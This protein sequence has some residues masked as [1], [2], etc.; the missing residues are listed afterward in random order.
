MDLGLQGVPCVVTGAS[1]GIG[2]AVAARLVDEGARVLIVARTSDALERAA[3]EIGAESLQADVGDPDKAERVVDECVARLGGIGVL[4]A[5]AGTMTNVPLDELGDA[6]WQ[7]QFSLNVLG[8]MRMIKRAAPI[9]EAAG[10]GRIVVVSSTAARR[11]TVANAAYSVAK[12]AQLSLSAVFAQAWASRGVIINAVVPGGTI[13][14][15]LWV[16]EGGLADQ[17][18]RARG[19]EREQVLAD[20][21]QSQP[22]KRLGTPEEVA[23]VIAFLCSSRA[24]YVAGA[25]WSVDGGSLGTLF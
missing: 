9:M 11:P 22:L 3:Q 8:P 25:A 21:V 17:I 15:P 12:A 20:R 23:D 6:H 16:G 5:N 2:L 4:V 7:Q 13:T 24:T 1:R 18:A 14:S 10:G 19:V